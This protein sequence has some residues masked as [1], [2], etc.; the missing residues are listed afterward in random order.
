M[1]LNLSPG[2]EARG[3]VVEVEY[4]D[5]FIRLVLVF[6][7]QVA[8][9][10]PRQK[11]VSGPLLLQPNEFVSILRTDTGYYILTHPLDQEHYPSGDNS[12]PFT[13]DDVKTTK[14]ESLC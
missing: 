9:L 11:L 14:E 4:T 5:D 8:F 10:I 3:K 7:K 2:D 13:I 6:N 1:Y 12:Q